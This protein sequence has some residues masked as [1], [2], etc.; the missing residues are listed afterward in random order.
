MDG[1]ILDFDQFIAGPDTGVVAGPPG[2][3]IACDDAN[4]AVAR[5]VVEP[6]YAVIMQRVGTK[7]VEPEHGC[8]DG[9]DCQDQ[10]ESS[11]ELIPSLAHQTPWNRE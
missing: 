9:G 6:G 2:E 11:G 7:V 3:D 1:K 10:Q 4:M 8:D 5:F